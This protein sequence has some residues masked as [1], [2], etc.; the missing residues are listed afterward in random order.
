M[1]MQ[2]ILDFTSDLSFK[3]FFLTYLY[4]LSN[5]FLYFLLF[6]QVLCYL[7]DNDVTLRA[8]LVELREWNSVR[9]YQLF[10]YVHLRF[11][12]GFYWNLAIGIVFRSCHDELLRLS[13]ALFIQ[14][15]LE[16][17]TS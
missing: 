9:H 13:Y 5:L 4:V 2:P 8:A 3:A 6:V 11:K 12:H 17:L 16:F 1:L 7:W 15:I 14:V 10:N